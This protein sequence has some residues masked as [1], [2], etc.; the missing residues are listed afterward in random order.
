MV[1]ARQSKIFIVLVEP[2][3][4][5]T[6]FPRAVTEQWGSRVWHNPNL[7]QIL[8]PVLVATPQDV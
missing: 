3:A 4:K 6:K 7:H 2:L 8:F 1:D 5:V